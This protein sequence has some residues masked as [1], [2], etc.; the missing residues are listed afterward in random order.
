VFLTS[1][2]W[3]I[4]VALTAVICTRHLQIA[5]GTSSEEGSVLALAYDALPLILLLPWVIAGLAAWGGHLVLM[6]AALVLCGYH[7]AL[8]VPRLVPAPTPRWVA[9]APR[10][11]LVVANVFVDNET[12]DDAA[13]QIVETAADVVVI[14]ESTADFM[15]TFDRCGGSDAYPNRIADPDVT[16]D[17]AIAVVTNGTLGPRT[18]FR[19]IGPLRVA[20][21]DIDV[22]G[23]STLI[24]AL[25]PTATVDDGGQEVW[26]EQ[27]A[28]LVDFLPT[29]TGPV[30][31]AG[32]LNSTRYRPEFEQILELGFTD[33]IDA[34]GEGLS[35]SFKLTA[36]NE[37]GAVVRLDH[38]LT[39]AGVHGTS[40]RNLEA[41]GSDHLPFLLELAVRPSTA[42]VSA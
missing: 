17:Y 16:S 39:S 35:P 1:L 37:V 24:V 21:A 25:N 3:L 28:A 36:G 22:D 15:A 13:R 42:R 26:E 14:V 5:T 30:M 31:V 6:T 7:V 4:C 29:L 23:T 20:I 34:L 27:L 18:E 10:M 41:C 38:A 33:A 11:T 2:G 32:D 12:P 8:V 9:K 40:M 19:A